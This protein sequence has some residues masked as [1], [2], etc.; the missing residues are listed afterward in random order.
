ME[1]GSERCIAFTW[2]DNWAGAT[3][4]ALSPYSTVRP[5]QNWIVVHM[6]ADGRY[7]VDYDATTLT[8]GCTFTATE[9]K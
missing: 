2:L 8:N 5:S 3:A 6:R 1:R 9:Y 7:A 4:S